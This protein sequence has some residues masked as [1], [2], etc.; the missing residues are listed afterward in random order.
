[1]S[2]ALWASRNDVA[3]LLRYRTKAG[4]VELAFDTRR[5]G[6]ALVQA[7][8]ALDSRATGVEL[9]ENGKPVPRSEYVSRHTAHRRPR[10]APA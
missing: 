10:R 4:P 9:L 2:P 1:M 8:V 6:D 7:G 5:R 3:Y